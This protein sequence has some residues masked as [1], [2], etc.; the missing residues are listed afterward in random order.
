MFKKPQQ[1]KP[2]PSHLAAWR[3]VQAPPSQ[4]GEKGTTEAQ[5]A[6]GI[7]DREAQRGFWSGGAFASVPYS[8]NSRK[9]PTG[10]NQDHQAMTGRG[11]SEKF[12]GEN[13]VT[14]RNEVHN[15]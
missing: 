9:V 6:G 2:S 14:K 1:R 12:G 10:P 13:S 7:F 11:L 4:K 15:G 5:G 8:S 3:T